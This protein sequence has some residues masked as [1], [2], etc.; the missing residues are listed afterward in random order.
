MV[1]AGAR[2]RLAA[3]VVDERVERDARAFLRLELAQG[4]VGR[5]RVVVERV[6]QV[7]KVEFGGEN[8]GRGGHA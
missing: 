8:G 4:A 6:A 7:T 1:D 2:E 3:D 5:K